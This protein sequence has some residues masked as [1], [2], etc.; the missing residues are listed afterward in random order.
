MTYQCMRITQ[1][2]VEIVHWPGFSSE[3]TS[4]FSMDNLNTHQKIKKIVPPFLSYNECI[5]IFNF[6]LFFLRKKKKTALCLV[7]DLKLC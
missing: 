6:L 3:K 4:F 5:I 2:L 1:D 7:D